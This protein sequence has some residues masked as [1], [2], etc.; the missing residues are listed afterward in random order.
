[1]FGQ[2]LNLGE[3]RH[4]IHILHDHLQ[5]FREGAKRGNIACGDQ[6]WLQLQDQ[7]IK[8]A[9]LTSGRNWICA[10]FEVSKGWD[11]GPYAPKMLAFANLG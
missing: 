8:S 6:Y 4:I 11:G 2:R 10:N 5:S 7:E 9:K 1:M 3:I